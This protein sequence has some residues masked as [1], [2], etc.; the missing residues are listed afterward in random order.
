MAEVLG[1]YNM[2]ADNIDVAV[3]DVASGDYGNMT[4]EKVVIHIN[5][6]KKSDIDTLKEKISAKT[7]IDVGSIYIK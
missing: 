3:S 1:E 7:G 5:R 2:Q 4:V 6:L